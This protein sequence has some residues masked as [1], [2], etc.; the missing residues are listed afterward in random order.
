ML[1]RQGGS[2]SASQMRR[3]VGLVARLPGERPAIAADVTSEAF[4]APR[5]SHSSGFAQE[6]YLELF[7]VAFLHST[8]P[9]NDLPE[10]QYQ[11]ALFEFLEAAEPV[12]SRLSA[13]A[14]P[15]ECGVL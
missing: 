12:M 7:G 8:A 10:V 4:H 15:S 9:M 14:L 2:L 11:E 13:G 5:S 1:N 3:L 6:L